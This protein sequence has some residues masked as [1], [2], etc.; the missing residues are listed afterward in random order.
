MMQ[1][2]IVFGALGLLGSRLCPFLSDNGINVIKQSRGVD[3]DVQIDP[4]DHD[5]I[6]FALRRYSPVAVINLIAET[7]VDACEEFL[8][9]AWIANVRVVSTISHC[10]EKHKME[11]FQ[12]VHLIHLSTDQLYSG[13]G[14]HVESS[15]K[16]INV[17][18]LSKLTGELFA[19]R[20]GATIL[21]T[22]FFGRTQHK[23]R[24]SFSDWLVNALKKEAQLILFEDVR[25]SALHVNSLCNV[26]LRCLEIQ[27][28][29]VFNLG[30]RNGISKSE[31]GITLANM[32]GF[33]TKNI[34]IESISKSQLKAPRSNDMTLDNSKIE[35]KLQII[36]PNIIQEIEITAQE[37]LHDEFNKTI[38][39]S[40]YIKD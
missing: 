16:P 32:L 18:G 36:C 31:F 34:L 22:N 13:L 5:E 29:G 2:V 12:N 19:E 24:K 14:P 40:K 21:R 30:C 38:R 15:M 28:S 33:T 17:Y 6:A 1:N 4:T 39:T 25:F 3:G 7:N 27:P 11:T 10:I 8:Q 20:V 26:I 23:N 9:K 35:E 37:Y